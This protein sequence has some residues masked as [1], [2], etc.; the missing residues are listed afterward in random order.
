MKVTLVLVV[1]MSLMIAM[2]AS[3]V[4]QEFQNSVNGYAGGQSTSISSNHAN[5]DIGGSWGGYATVLQQNY[6]TVALAKFDGMGIP[7]GAT[8]NSATLRAY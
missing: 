5:Q 8:I 1:V 7:T 4:V 2:S 6:G 3:A